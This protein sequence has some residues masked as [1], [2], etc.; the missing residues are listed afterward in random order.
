MGDF[1]LSQVFQ[2]VS[3]VSC[4]LELE[5]FFSTCNYQSA[6]FPVFCQVRFKSEERQFLKHDTLTMCW[7]YFEFWYSL[8]YLLLF[9]FQSPQMFC[10]DLI[11]LFSGRRGVACVFNILPRTGAFRYLFLNICK[12][13][14]FKY[15]QMYC[16]SCVTHLTIKNHHQRRLDFQVLV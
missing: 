16:P 8:I 6:Q 7:W 2:G 13:K 9:T 15:L 4:K 12:T 3:S 14:Q 1:L 11:V 5:V 10:P